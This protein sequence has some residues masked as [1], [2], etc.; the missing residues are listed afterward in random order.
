MARPSETAG[1]DAWELL[2]RTH[3]A[4]VP[5]LGRLVEDATGLPLTWYDV[6][7]ELNRAP[8]RRLRMTELSEQVVLSRSQVSR[9]VDEM[10][11]GDLVTKQPDPADGRATLALLTAK[12]RGALRRAGPVYLEG[13]ERMFSSR[14]SRPET[15]AV[16]R[17]LTR[18]LE[19]HL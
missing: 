11:E 12:G 9:L 19:Q 2:L 16:T 4:L 10:V 15:E 17:A 18:V 6:L 7:L 3:A 5:E 14:I 1:T 13:I 8:E